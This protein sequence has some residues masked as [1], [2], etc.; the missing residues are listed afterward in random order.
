MADALEYANRQGTLHRDI[1]PSNLLLDNHANVWVADFGL[2]KTAEAD[3]LTHTGDILGTIRYMAPERFQGKCDARSDVFSLGLTLY[4][5]IALRPA[6]QASDRHELME[7]DQRRA[8]TLEEAGSQRAARPRDN[9]GQGELGEPSLRYATAGA[10]AEDLR[11]FVE[12]RPIK[13]RRVSAPRAARALVQATT[14]GWPAR[15][16]W[17]PGRWCWR[18]GLS[19]LHS[20]RQARANERIG[21]LASNL[22]M[23]SNSLREE[24]ARLKTALAESRSRTARLDLERGRIACERGEIGV[25][26]LWMLESLRMAREAGDESLQ[27]AALFNLSAWKERHVEPRET[28]THDGWVS[29]AVFS[30][31]GKTIATASQDRTARLWDLATGAAEG[32]GHAS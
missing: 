4:E 21:E 28:F 12:D 26:M 22:K 20:Y 14:P 25:G 19:L 2:A 30:P 6:Y 9:R 7:R 31:D 23:E 3:D 32:R 18:C 16:V 10:L 24:R 5:L 15:W 29:C 1:K 27:H 13:A 17:Q 8:G 11:R